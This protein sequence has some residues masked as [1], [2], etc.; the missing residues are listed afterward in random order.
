MQAW[1]A[2][3]FRISTTTTWE[4]FRYRVCPG[5]GLSELFA[6]QRRRLEEEKWEDEWE[7]QLGLEDRV[8]WPRR[9]VGHFYEEE[10]QEEDYLEDQYLSDEYPYHKEEEEEEYPEYPGYRWN[11]ERGRYRESPRGQHDYSSVADFSK[12]DYPSAVSSKLDY[13]LQSKLDYPNFPDYNPYYEPLVSVS[14]VEPILTD[15][16]ADRQFT[17]AG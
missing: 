13:P 5:F 9:R 17:T 12:L 1:R 11:F 14:T 8:A 16:A 10:E 2:I 7:D 6:L 3:F 4:S 15:E